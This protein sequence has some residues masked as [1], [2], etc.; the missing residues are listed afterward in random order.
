MLKAVCIAAAL[1]AAS[2]AAAGEQPHASGGDSRRIVPE[3]LAVKAL[4]G[5]NGVLDVTAVT[6]QRAARGPELYVALRNNGDR[7]ACDAAVAVELFDAGE[8][9]LAAG[10][11]GLRA[12]HFFRRTDGSG[13][14]VN[15]VAPG[16][17]AM[18]DVKDLPSDLAIDDLRFLL[19]RCPYFA[20]D[21]EP[22]DGLPIRGLKSVTRNHQTTYTGTLVNLFDRTLSQA[23]V[24]VFPV[25]RV[26]RPLSV[27]TDSS[28]AEVEPDGRWAFATAAIDAEGVHALAYPAGA[29]SN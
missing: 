2:C 5:G 24:F 20:L 8:Q 25:N 10:I 3:Q 17:V 14:I 27:A 6:L 28:E 4:P 21:V 9:S 11:G 18:A 19:Y 15:C 16:D 12:E 26:G 7:P 13:A 23:A 22:I 29:L 1:L